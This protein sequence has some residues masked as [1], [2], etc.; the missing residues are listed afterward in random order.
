MNL[1]T[2]T[3]EHMRAFNIALVGICA[4]LY[5]VTGILTSFGLT[6]GG[7]AFWPAAVVPAVFAVLFGPWVGAV[8]ASIGI[9][10]RDMLFHGNPLLSLTAGVT[11]NFVAFF[12]IGYLARTE[13]SRKKLVFA[14]VVSVV[15]ILGGMLLPTLLLPGESTGFTALSFDWTITIFAVLSVF[16]LIALLLFARKYPKSR[17]F[18]VATLIGQG[19]GAAVL[20]LGV[21]VY[22]QLFFGQGAYFI[23]PV[24]ASFAPVIFVWTFATEVPFVLLIAPPIIRVCY[25]AFPSLQKRVEAKATT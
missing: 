14:A 10:I 2:K 6:F 1:A 4:A 5:T 24:P 11:G 18:A 13:L 8:G 23:S 12:L 16:T 17:N 20:T 22:S 9:F 25:R 7:V 21:W 15:S 3:N 19:T